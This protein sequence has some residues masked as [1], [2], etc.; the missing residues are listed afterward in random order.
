MAMHE[1]VLLAEENSKLR[2]ANQKQKAKKQGR[3]KHVSKKK[4]LTIT[5]GQE[6]LR[7]PET[8]VVV[9]EQPRVQPAARANSGRL[10][11]C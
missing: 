3:S 10:P 4:V 7:P 1:A 2:A 8:P 6:I 9:A 5:Q 11:M